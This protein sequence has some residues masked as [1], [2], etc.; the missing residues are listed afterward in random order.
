MNLQEANL[1]VNGYYHCHMHLKVGHGHEERH[2]KESYVVCF[3]NKCLH[4][5]LVQWKKNNNNKKKKKMNKMAQ[6]DR[7][8]LF[9]NTLSGPFD[10]IYLLVDLRNFQI[11]F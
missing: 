5:A 3:S 6:N 8:H 2:R 11:Y 10:S 4:F 1:L 7:F 9:K